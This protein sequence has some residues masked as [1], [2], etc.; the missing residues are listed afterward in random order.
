MAQIFPIS[1]EHVRQL[2]TAII[3]FIWKGTVFRVPMYTLQRRREDGGLELLDIEAKCFALFLTKMRDQG[4]K[5]GTLPAAW[6][7]RWDLRKPEGN[8]TNVRRIPRTF[9]YL[10]IYA[11]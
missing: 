1:K 10:R 6:L 11:L 2:A 3:W 4:A 5:E 9:E 8:P 7:Q